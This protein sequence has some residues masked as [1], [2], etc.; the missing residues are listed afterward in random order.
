MHPNHQIYERA[1]KLLEAF[2]SDDSEAIGMSDST[3]TP[4]GDSGLKFNF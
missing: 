4:G 2:F 1:V 3:A